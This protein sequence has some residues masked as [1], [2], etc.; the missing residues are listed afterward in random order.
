MSKRTMIEIQI[1][2]LV[3]IASTARDRFAQLAIASR[4]ANEVS[5][6]V[7]NMINEK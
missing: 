5:S 4:V 7:E 2:D 1:C 3:L 6:T